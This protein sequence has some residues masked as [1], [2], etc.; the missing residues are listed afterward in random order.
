MTT[1][2]PNDVQAI[3]ERLLAEVQQPGTALTLDGNAQLA[4]LGRQAI[5]CAGSPTVGGRKSGALARQVRG[6]VCRL[7][8]WYVEPFVLQQRS[9]NLALVRHIAQLEQRIAELEG[10]KPSGDR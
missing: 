5:V 10:D 8:R 3:Y 7:T 6:T 9:F 1:D 4:E 2:D